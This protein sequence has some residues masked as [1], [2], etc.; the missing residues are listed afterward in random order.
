MA[1]LLSH[2]LSNM[3]G[4]KGFSSAGMPGDKDAH[5]LCWRSWVREFKIFRG[6]NKIPAGCRS[7]ETLR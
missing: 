6:P 5:M 1:F 7:D 3:H 4:L 2:F